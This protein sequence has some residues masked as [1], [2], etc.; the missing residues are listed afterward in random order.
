[1]FVLLVIRVAYP[2]FLKPDPVVLRKIKWMP[3]DTSS[4][5]YPATRLFKFDPNTVS[6]EQLLL[7][8]FEK[9]SARGY[10]NYRSKGFRFRKK[11]DVKKIYGVSDSLY[12]KLIPYVNIENAASG[13]TEL[14]ATPKVTREAVSKQTV[15]L[16][17]NAAD[18]AQLLLVRGIGPVFAKRILRYR[19]LLG[20]FYSL[21]QLREVYGMTEEIFSGISSQLHVN[22]ALVRKLALATADFKTVNRHPYIT[23]E[24]TK[25]IFAMRDRKTLSGESLRAIAG[26]SLYERL[27]VYVD[28]P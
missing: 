15:H 12:R 3:V 7:L 23:Y 17:L 1:M 20:G 27:K 14:S 19:E 21:A 9:R 16:E 4:N 6:Y 26:D 10:I 5:K 8:G 2:H 28:I 24:L 25:K 13:P 18:S 22:T 11:E